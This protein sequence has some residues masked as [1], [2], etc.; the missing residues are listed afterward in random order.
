MI[1]ALDQP[2]DRLKGLDAGADDF[3]TKPVD[4]TALFARVRSLM[5]LK[6]V[7]DELRAR[8]MGSSSH[9]PNDPLA[10]AA[11]VTGL[12]GDLLLVDDR[13]SSSGR[14]LAALSP[15]HSRSAWQGMPRRNGAGGAPSGPVVTGRENGSAASKPASSG[16]AHSLTRMLPGCT[17][18][19]SIP[20][21]C[22]ASSAP[23]ILMPTAE[24][25]GALIG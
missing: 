3:L 5:R 8:L 17:S 19:C 12:D 22:T 4:D 13:P 23:A 10:A 6:A 18:Q 9:G 1:T 20:A 15:Y 24:V 7:T 16:S 21:R 14:L 25:S 2:S 11:A